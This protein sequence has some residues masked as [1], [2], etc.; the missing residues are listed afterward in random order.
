MAAKQSKLKPGL[1]AKVLLLILILISIVIFSI[2]FFVLNQQTQILRENVLKNAEGE[3]ASLTYLGARALLDQDD[4][5]LFDSL[6]LASKTTGF[7]YGTI[8]NADT[9]NPAAKIYVEPYDKE[10][11]VLSN[12]WQ[13]ASKDLW[14]QFKKKETKEII[15]KQFPYPEKAKINIDVF[16]QAVYHPFIKPNPPLL[17]IVQIAFSD[18][19]IQKTVEKNRNALVYTGLLFWGIGILGALLLSHFIVK[20]IKQ[21]SE[22]AK[23]VGEGNLDYK[24][25]VKSKDEL[26]MLADQFNQMT[27]GLKQAKE[28]EAEQLVLD[29]QIKQAQEIQQGMNPQEFL[30]T[31]KYEVKGF[32]RAAK[33][34]GGDYYDFQELDNN[35]LAVLISDVSGKSISASLVMV[36][37]KTVVS[38]YLKLFKFTRGDKI[39]TAINK[40]MC[41]ESH[42]DKFATIMMCVY[43]SNDRSLEFT[44]GGH[45]PIFL[46]RARQKVC[47][48]TKLSG[49]P[50]GID[51]DNE[52]GLSK[53]E[54]EPEDMVVF[55]TD[56]I[57]EARNLKEAEFGLDKLRKKIIEYAPF[58]AKEI[59]DKLIVDL[60]TFS[61]GA[62]QHD[63]MTLVVL[64]T[65]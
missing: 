21:L 19:F 37:I 30:K 48:V 55:Y 62:P 63:D 38:T 9:K 2:G 32:M 33:G 60:D 31:D 28:A 58:N 16:H 50:M 49:L 10:E 52:Y 45:G 39:I 6:Q 35:R 40:V 47:T 65:L 29:E 41:A 26:G 54:L 3:A 15:K 8:L 53:L 56:G 18:E 20:P 27:T 12:I 14:E 59:V 1:R 7:V 13:N 4:L 46:Y 36:L 5:A 43:D 11:K 64:K 25:T 51:E 61:E 17:G 24:V 44:N 23:I 42:I 34:V 57:T 22:G